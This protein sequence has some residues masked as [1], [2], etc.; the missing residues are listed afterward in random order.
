MWS[1]FRYYHKLKFCEIL[2]YLYVFLLLVLLESFLTSYQNVNLSINLI[3][4]PNHFSYKSLKTSEISGSLNKPLS[5]NMSRNHRSGAVTATLT[6]LVRTWE[7]VW[8]SCSFSSLT[9]H[10]SFIR[11]VLSVY[12][13][14]LSHSFRLLCGDR[15][16]EFFIRHHV[17][18]PILPK[19]ISVGY[20]FL[21]WQFISLFA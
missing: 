12:R 11:H 17:D 21:T 15:C 6:K 1:I 19:N 2:S 18:F 13:T 20:R 9:S 4:L 10:G 3:Y 14:P 8:R 7:S 16:S 5:V